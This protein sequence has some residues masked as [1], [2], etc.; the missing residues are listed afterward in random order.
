MPVICLYRFC[1]CSNR[2]LSISCTCSTLHKGSISGKGDKATG[3]P[4]GNGGNGGN[5][6]NGKKVKGHTVACGKLAK[7]KRFFT[8]IYTDVTNSN[9]R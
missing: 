6:V 7:E 4:C 2:I 1:E 5:R 8:Q 3:N 9:V